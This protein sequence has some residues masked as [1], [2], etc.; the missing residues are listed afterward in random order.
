MV[1][2]AIKQPPYGQLRVAKDKAAVRYGDPA[3][4]GV[5]C[6]GATRYGP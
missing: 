5:L 3:S 4:R 1:E 6:S 2:M